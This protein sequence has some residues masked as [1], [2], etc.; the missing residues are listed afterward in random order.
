MKNMNYEELKQKLAEAFAAT[1]NLQ[2]QPS[3]T[4]VDLLA[5]I[6]R[7]LDEVYGEIKEAEMQQ[8]ESAPPEEAEDDKQEEG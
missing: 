5:L 3:K 8:V 6:L 4:N 7:N 2:L 1:Q